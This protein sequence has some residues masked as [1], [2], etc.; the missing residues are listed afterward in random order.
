MRNDFVRQVH[1]E[2][3]KNKN[4]F[5]LTGDLGFNAL[6]SIQK[7]FPDRFINVGIAEGNMIGVAAGLA[8]QGKKVI[9][10]SIASFVTMRAFEQIRNDI[11]Y[12]K[13]DV[14]IIGTGGGYNY[15]QHGVTHHT[16]EDIALMSSLPTM[17]VFNPGYSWE[18][19]ECTKA[20]LADSGPAYIRLGK[21]PDKEFTKPEVQFAL[22]KGYVM[23]EGKDILILSTGNLVDYALES[24]SILKKNIGIDARVVSI[25]SV[26]PLDVEQI[27]ELSHGVKLVV[28]LEEHSVIGGFG[29]QIA[30]ILATA[31]SPVDF[32]PLGIPDTFIKSVG[33]R[34]FLLKEA[35]L[36]PVSIS[37]KIL[38]K[39]KK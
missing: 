37:M 14:K 36:D 35:G 16:I 3:E 1:A 39:L 23:R 33:T 26:K 4:I 24:A 27:V 13:L 6:E 15:A 12:H 28:T 8:L 25:P 2:M 18:A 10:Y 21:K 32:L 20:L 38:W 22:G 29:S 11:C 31:N 30:T 34:P 19:I 17:K 5:F 9:A 7:D